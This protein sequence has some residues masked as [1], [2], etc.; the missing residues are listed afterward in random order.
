MSNFRQWPISKIYSMSNF[1][2]W[3]S[4]DN[5]SSFLISHFSFLISHFSFRAHR[6]RLL[7]N[8]FFIPHFPHF[9]HLVLGVG[10]VGSV[11]SFSYRPII[12]TRARRNCLPRFIQIPM[13]WAKNG[14]QSTIFLLRE[15]GNKK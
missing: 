11:A 13:K 10:S 6:A 12:H 8:S 4:G 1:R 3:P 7:P 14:L 2:Q 9:P 5:H 15:N